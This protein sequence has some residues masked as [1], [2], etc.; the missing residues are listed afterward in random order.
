MKLI[1]FVIGVSGLFFTVCL[2]IFAISTYSVLQ[3][4]IL[5]SKEWSINKLKKEF[6]YKYI[7]KPTISKV[8]F[9]TISYYLVSLSLLL[10]L[11]TSTIGVYQVDLI[12]IS[13]SNTNII[14]FL[15]ISGS[16]FFFANPTFLVISKTIS[17]SYVL[18]K[19]IQQYNDQKKH[20]E[21]VKYR[22]YN[23]LSNLL[24]SSI[25]EDHSFENE[26][27]CIKRIDQLIDK[28][29]KYNMSI[30]IPK[31]QIKDL[32]IIAYRTNNIRLLNTIYTAYDNYYINTSTP[33]KLSKIL[34][35]WFMSTFKIKSNGGYINNEYLKYQPINLV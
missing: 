16:C 13:Q 10:M 3:N 25:L 29:V 9:D 27:A 31:E 12:D 1:D 5:L 23:E 7:D 20:P 34:R 32:K 21:R 19:T 15:L 28:L 30:N 6:L 11:F 22:I 17:Y 4:K 14:K 18:I 8:I 24:N 35:H 26:S 2:I 33:S